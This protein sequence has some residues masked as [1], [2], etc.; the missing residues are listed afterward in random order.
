MSDGANDG[1]DVERQNACLRAENEALR[2]SEARYRFLVESLP[3]LVWTCNGKGESVDFSQRCLDY[4]GLTKDEAIHGGWSAKIHPDDREEAE[5][6]W[7]EAVRSASAYSAEYRMKRASDGAYRWFTDKALPMRDEKGQIV[8][9]CGTSIDIDDEKHTKDELFRS[10]FLL[11]TVVSNSPTVFVA[12]D[13]KGNINLL[14]GPGLGALQITDE[15]FMGKPIQG[16]CADDGVHADFVKRALSGESCQQ[17]HQRAGFWLDIR[18]VPLRDESGAIIGM[19]CVATDATEVREKE[20]TIEANE[21]LYRSLMEAMPALVWSLDVNGRATYVNDAFQELTGLTLAD[22][23]T[24]GHKAFIHADDLEE[25]LHVRSRALANR[26]ACSFENRY[27]RRDGEYRWYVSSIRPVLGPDGT[28]V[29]WIGTALDIH[30][31]KVLE[32]ARRKSE[33]RLRLVLEAT[34]DGVWDLNYETGERFWSPRLFELLGLVPGSVTP[35]QELF[36]SLTHP[37]DTEILK[38]AMA[39]HLEKHEPY[40]VQFRIRDFDGEY[41]WRETRGQASF[42]TDGK[43][44]RMVGAV[45]DIHTQRSAEDRIRILNE[46]LEE[47]VH[48][49][50]SALEATTGE[51]QEFCYS[52][53]HDLRG[54]LR[55]INGFGKAL[56]ED[57]GHLL[58][59]AG[60]ENIARIR[61]AS[62]RLSEL[63]DAL[64]S[65][66]RIT[67]AEMARQKV[68]LSAMAEGILE[69][70]AVAEP[71]REVEVDVAP[72]L[73]TYGDEA[74]LRIALT[75]LLENAWKFTSKTAHAEISVGQVAGE[76]DVFYVKDNGAGFDMKYVNKLF[77]PFQRLHTASEFPGTGIGLAIVNRVVQRHG[78]TISAQ[79]ALGSGST[80]TFSLPSRRSDR[81]K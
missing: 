34:H 37:D 73:D 45:S 21:R 38:T 13:A 4:L 40:S 24:L 10:H 29:Q 35:T 3:H 31:G 79:S 30:D 22:Y 59:D 67:R 12:T 49:R 77:A 41:R 58:D 80:F 5:S 2:K 44:V 28:L 14:E 1:K 66:S 70:L 50:T 54:P 43:P 27:R 17:Y 53:S 25:M 69:E 9:W 63:I 20:R 42:D 57:Y 15:E 72:D 65:M 18:Y 81:R 55:S 76:R 19:A 74:L 36:L 51:L 75:N 46:S 16:L 60:R 71:D 78:G 33:E 23:N 68:N 47:R 62:V 32:E 39:N 61:N 8:A 56:E 52:V 48:E 7:S 6:L 26:E 64:L 11:K